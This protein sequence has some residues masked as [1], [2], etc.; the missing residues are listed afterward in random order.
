[1]DP[2]VVRGLEAGVT[3]LGIIFASWMAADLI[4][5]FVDYIRNG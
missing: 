1:M 3:A 5:D 4:L 2:V